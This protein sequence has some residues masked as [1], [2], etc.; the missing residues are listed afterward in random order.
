HQHVIEQLMIVRYY[1]RFVMSRADEGTAVKGLVS[2]DLR[3]S[4]L[5]FVS[6]SAVNVATGG[7]GRIYQFTTNGVIKTGDGMAISYRAGVPLKDMEFI[8]F[9]PTALP[10]TGILI[11]EASRG[12]GGYLKNK[13]GERVMSR[14]RH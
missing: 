11:T 8:Q 14:Y 6:A 5:A 10:G 7:S 2:L 9:H 1:K 13:D 12:E 4:E 3:T